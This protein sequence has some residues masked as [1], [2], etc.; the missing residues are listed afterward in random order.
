MLVLSLLFLLIGACGANQV[1]AIVVVR[2]DCGSEGHLSLHQR[3]PFA[4]QVGLIQPFSSPPLRSMQS[5]D[6]HT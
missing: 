6:W 4:I 3:A 5:S 1:T 2:D